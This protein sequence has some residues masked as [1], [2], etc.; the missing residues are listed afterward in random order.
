VICCDNSIVGSWL[1]VISQRHQLQACMRGLAAAQQQCLDVAQQRGKR[2]ALKKELDSGYVL[3]C[4]CTQ[5]REQI[6]VGRMVR[7]YHTLELVFSLLFDWLSQET[8]LLARSAAA[9]KVG[10]AVECLARVYWKEGT[11]TTSTS[12]Y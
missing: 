1:Q 6:Q 9:L 10:S 11:G 7:L 3:A 4:Q 12:W 8:V 5:A 2:N